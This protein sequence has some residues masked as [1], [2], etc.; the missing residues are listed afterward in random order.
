MNDMSPDESFPRSAELRSRDWILFG[1]FFLSGALALVYEICWIRKASSVFGSESFALSCVLAVF[2]G[3]LALGSFLIGRRTPG[4][5]SPLKWYGALE[6]AVGV[7][8]I[9]SPALFALADRVYGP[10]YAAL[11]N[12]FA[13]LTFVRCLLLTAVMLP[14]TVAMG[15]TFPVMCRWFVTAREHVSGRVGG[16]FALNTFGACLGALACGFYLIPKVG[17]DASIYFGGAI[18]VAL[19]VVV[20]RL[21]NDGG[22]VVTEEEEGGKAKETPAAS[23]GSV[24][25]IEA[26]FFASGF[27]ALGN[28]I[29]WTRFLSLILLRSVHTYTLVLAVVLFGLVVGAAATSRMFDGSQRRGAWFGALQMANGVF[30]LMVL[31]APA[32][33]WTRWLD[34]DGVARQASL[35]VLILLGPACLSGAAFPLAMRMAVE[36]PARAGAGVG[37]MTALNTVGGILG[38]IVFGFVLLPGLGMHATALLSTG[39]SVAAG[40]TAVL[41]VERN[42][43]KSGRLA[44]VFA[45]VALWGGLAGGMKTRLPADYLG[46]GGALVDY[47]EGVNAFVSVV[48]SE[49]GVRR[50]M[51]DRLWQGFNRRGHQ[52]MAAHIP[53]ALHP[54]P[55]EIAVVGMGAGQTPSRF[56]MYDIDRLDCVEIEG[57]TLN[58]IREHFAA[59]WMD[60]PRTHF[61]VDDGRNYLAHTRRSY[62]LISIEVGQTYRPG[63]ASF[64]TR[65]FYA[66][67][68][69]RL[70]HGGLLCQ[71]LPIAFFSVE[72]LEVLTATFLEEF[73]DSVLWYNTAELLLIGRRDE[74]PMIYTARSQALGTNVAVMRD[75]QFSYWGGVNYFLV[76]PHVFLGGFLLGP[77]G[78]HKLAEGAAI[79]RDNRP[80]LEYSSVR[81]RRPETDLVQRLRP[82][83]DPLAPLLEFKPGSHEIAAS[84]RV[85]DLNLRDIVASSMQDDIHA[86]FSAGDRER[87]LR[88]AR[89]AANWNPENLF[90]KMLLADE[91]SEEKRYEE[92]V[93]L[94]RSVIEAKPGFAVAHSNLG[95]A[96]AALGRLNEA[97]ACFREALKRDPSLESTRASLKQAIETRGRTGP[98]LAELK[99]TARRNPHNTFAMLDLAQGLFDAGD[100][101]GCI[102]E[103]RKLL[104]IEPES[105]T[106]LND[107]AWALAIAPEGQGRNPSEAVALAERAVQLTGRSS[108]IALGTL[109]AAH[110]AKGDFAKARD[111]SREA[112][113][114]SRREKEPEVERL[115]A[116]RLKLFEQG[117]DLRR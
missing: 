83:L 64:Y 44:L 105:P 21:S 65:E 4:C 97:V 29:L 53:M 71:F 62:D 87:G 66:A 80:W 117:R 85:R 63:V 72:E 78:L 55:R 59:E 93:E 91:L 99:E 17:I 24:G 8:A 39:L 57:E 116:E 7:F 112:I 46:R 70:K 60:D 11:E 37:R 51:I 26:L 56:L 106:A 68:G 77:E 19:G 45:G 107:L 31:L 48:D 20:M 81:A 82:L 18:S 75:L 49:G 90:L 25:A 94:Y 95:S 6:I 88:L 86:A 22:E 40:V 58:M 23:S 84:E 1:V 103:Y 110:A 73:P 42:M 50:L 38:S 12:R 74:R 13:A 34:A 54:D 15:G 32:E 61:I 92:A 104:R 14:P 111:L 67:A 113:A 27:V 101:P 98:S 9:L 2:F 47:R 69:K 10:A 114:M 41:A 5:R 109:A 96:L 36:D 89:E 33:F 3:G 52:V 102:A 108:A 115:L 16:L 79:Y 35:A 30:V 100:Y 76:H 28:E 43:P